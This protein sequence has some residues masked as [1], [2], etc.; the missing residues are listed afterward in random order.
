MS[1]VA[2]NDVIVYVYFVYIFW[3]KLLSVLCQYCQHVGIC[4]NLLFL[5][6]T[7]DQS[8]ATKIG[9]LYL[10]IVSILLFDSTEVTPVA[11]VSDVPVATGMFR[12]KTRSNADLSVLTADTGSTRSTS[13]VSP[14][15]KTTSNAFSE[16]NST[17]VNSSDHSRVLGRE[18]EDR[19]VSL[20]TARPFAASVDSAKDNSN[21]SSGNNSSGSYAMGTAGT[22][23]APKGFRG[24]HY[25]MSLMSLRCAVS[26][27]R[28]NVRC[29]I[30]PK[31]IPA[32]L[33]IPDL[34]IASIFFLQTGYPIN[35]SHNGNSNSLRV[36]GS[37]H[38]SSV[39]TIRPKKDRPAP[40]TDTLI[41]VNV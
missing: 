16:Q 40:T 7:L 9:S 2:F 38:Y 35:T 26:A 11:S 39:A 29:L 27:N 31:C 41:M 15:N 37:G 18:G 25:V 17:V 34:F 21:S 30:P 1:F 28:W 4:L 20:T 19:A 14:V 32:P 3:S 22:A 23:G 24:K 5:S 10:I 6:P 36:A 33:L 13:T 12:H 8:E